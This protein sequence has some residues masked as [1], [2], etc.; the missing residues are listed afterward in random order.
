LKNNL[1][2]IG[3]KNGKWILVRRESLGNGKVRD[4]WIL[5][6]TVIITPTKAY[7]GS[8]S[9][10]TSH[11]GN[12]S[13]A[14]T[15][16]TSTEYSNIASDDGV[17]ASLYATANVANRYCWVAHR[18][19]FDLTQYNTGGKRVTGLTYKWD[20]YSPGGSLA[21]HSYHKETTGWVQDVAIP[22]SDGAGF[23]ITKVITNVSASI[24]NNTFEFGVYV[25]DIYIDTAVTVYIYTDYV[26]LEV[27][28]EIDILDE[29]VGEDQ[30]TVG[31]V[32]IISDEGVGEDQLSVSTL[33]Y[34]TI[35]DEGVGEDQFSVAGVITISDEGVGEDQFTLPYKQLAFEDEGSGYD[36]FTY[37]DITLY[38]A[39]QK[40][41]SSIMNMVPLMLVMGALTGLIKA[42]KPKLKA[43]VEKKPPPKA[44][45]A[46][47]PKP[48]K[49]SE[50]EKAIEKAAKIKR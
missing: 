30:F 44:P 47:P 38:A 1:P 14:I 43:K 7:Q 15:E 28:Y 41:L 34:I 5:D 37:A 46:K 39:I 29:G 33:S 24:I 11:P 9:N 48:A 40:L 10:A 6:P 42:T 4:T 8:A 32:K 49:K 25:A 26:E 20:G 13:Q 17:Y 35:S 2:K 31:E 36:E 50:I 19:T 45:P 3:S 23:E 21:Y 12:P 16:F 27:T 22:T 18:F